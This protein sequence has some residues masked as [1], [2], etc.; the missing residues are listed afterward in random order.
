MSQNRTFGISSTVPS[1]AE[2][3][4]RV[5]AYLAAGLGVHKKNWWHYIANALGALCT[6]FSGALR[7]ITS[8]LI[9]LVYS[10]VVAYIV[11]SLKRRECALRLS[12]SLLFQI[13]FVLHGHLLSLVNLSIASLYRLHTPTATWALYVLSMLHWSAWSKWPI[14]FLKFE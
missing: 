12:T 7:S 8:L 6:I 13:S 10:S 1:S 4:S 11:N 5:F 14:L 2:P 3:S 9:C